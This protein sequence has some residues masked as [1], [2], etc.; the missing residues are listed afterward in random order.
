MTLLVISPD[1]ASHYG[2]LAVIARAVKESGR[3]VVVAT[4][5]GL[6]PRVEADGFKWRELNLAASSNT[7][8]VEKNPSIEKFLN[9]TKEGALETIRYQAM[10][11]QVDLL[12]QPEK[13]VKAIALIYAQIKPDQVLVDHVSFGSTLAM[14]ALAKPF[15]TLVP[16]H[17]SQLPVANER[18]GIPAQWP[19]CLSPEPAL[20]S[21]VEQ[22]ADTVTAAFTERWNAALKT[23]AP[24]RPPVK[25]AFRVH[26]SRVLYNSVYGIQNTHRLTQ[27]T[28]NHRFVGPLVRTEAL[29]ENLASWRQKKAHQ[30]QVYVALGTFLSHREDVLIRIAQALRAVGAR[31][32]IAIGS[33]QKEQLGPVPDDWIVAGQLPQVAMLKYAD[34]AIH[35]GGNN[36]VQECL[37][38]GVQQLVLPFSTDQFAN[39]TDLERAKVAQTLD[40][41]RMSTAQLSEAIQAGLNC[42]SPSPHSAMTNTC[43][44][45]ALFD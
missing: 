16:G 13:I 24:E 1:Y 20:L 2:P 18:Y 33:M 10:Q 12:W 31:A 17:P 5:N 32:A 8:V 14:Y 35:H 21:E 22:L 6:R 27:I 28:E 7:G 25:D 4:G 37:G 42:L 36:S 30:P 15:M 23:V 39:A 19:A 43:V 26:G 11:R 41:N 40:P 45:E 34:L 44:I 9:A 29:P 3:Q 38:V